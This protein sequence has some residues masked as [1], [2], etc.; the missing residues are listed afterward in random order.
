[1]EYDSVKGSW[2]S[3]VQN[4]PSPLVTLNIWHSCNQL[5][6]DLIKQQQAAYSVTGVDEEASA[7]RWWVDRVWKSNIR[8]W[9]TQDT[10]STRPETRKQE[11]KGTRGLHRVQYSWK[12]RCKFF[13]ARQKWQ[14]PGRTKIKE[15]RYLCYWSSSGCRGWWNSRTFLPMWCHRGRRWRRAQSEDVRPGRWFICWRGSSSVL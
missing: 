12:C 9:V 4:S 13:Q 2:V 14:I 3:L 15:H 1:M 10:C 7:L 8:S 11:E 5:D 6:E